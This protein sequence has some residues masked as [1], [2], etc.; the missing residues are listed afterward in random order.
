MSCRALSPL[1]ALFVAVAM[2][3][4]AAWPAAPGKG[5]RPG[6]TRPPT[7]AESA[8]ALRVGGDTFAT[9]LPI[10]AV[11]FTDSGSTV[12]YADDYD[13]ACGISLGT[14]PDVVYSFVPAA[15]GWFRFDLCGSSYDTKM[16]IYDGAGVLL[17]CNDDFDVDAGEGEPCHLNARI[18]DFP[19]AAGE[20]YYVVVDGY[21]ASAGDYTFTASAW[22]HC[23]VV[24]DAGA[25]DEGE[26]ALASG[27]VDG[28]NPG[29]VDP[30]KPIYGTIVGD[31]AGQAVIALRH[32]WRDAGFR[33]LDCFRLTAGPSGSINVEFESELEARIRI[34][35]TADCQDFVEADMATVVP[36]GSAVLNAVITP[37]SDFVISITPV[38]YTSPWGVTPAEF[39]GVL[40]VSGLTVG[41]PIEA[42][43]W[44]SVKGRYR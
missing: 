23:D 9:A 22:T 4:S 20:T 2:V 15:T 7:R 19:C 31:A 3:P 10:A 29:C 27:Q 17:A 12:G 28:F 40:R 42:T 32:G 21:D 5:L 14:A 1:F 26:P 13:A 11:P 44:G 33:D 24:P 43:S 35:T 6:V 8:A 36:C 37:G 25:T 34:R 30:E 38:Q 18:A 16:F 39:D 41:V